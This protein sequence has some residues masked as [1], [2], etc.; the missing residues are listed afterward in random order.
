MSARD[1]AVRRLWRERPRS[2]FVRVSVL[3]FGLLLIGCWLYVGADLG[4]VFSPE[5]ADDLHEF[6]TEDAR[7]KPLRGEA[8]DW[9]VAARWA[10]GELDARGWAAAGATL[11]ISILA[12]VL[13]AAFAGL[14]A[15][16]AA[17]TFATPEAFIP[18]GR[19][20][21]WLRRTAWKAVVA[22]TR[23]GLVLM[24]SLPEYVLA[25][26]LFTIVGKSA[27]PAVLALMIHNTGILGRLDA[28][29]IEN[30]PP[31]TL[32][33]QRALG[34]GRAQLGLFGV[35]PAALP[36]FLMYFFYRWE[37]CVREAT[38]LSMIGLAGLGYWIK[39]ADAHDREDLLLLYVLVSSG[40]V[41]IGDFVSAIARRV[42]RQAS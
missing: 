42:V 9:G 20:P 32:A 34:A 30:L 25:F 16:P 33:A 29:V 11:A 21:S 13:A 14:L 6:F 41:L 26:L 10:S 31:R 38:V 36:R 2:R 28:E 17:R 39:E 18:S 23:V 7:P 1:D 5:G 8:W 27:W 37:T 15:W 24:R 12:I 3:L 40:L 22:G 35:L 4:V 19:E